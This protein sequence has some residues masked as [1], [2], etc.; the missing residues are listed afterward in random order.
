MQSL[1][2]HLYAIASSRPLAMGVVPRSFVLLL[3]LFL[4]GLAKCGT[5]IHRCVFL[6]LQEGTHKESRPPSFHRATVLTEEKA[7]SISDPLPYAIDVA[8]ASPPHKPLL[9]RHLDDPDL[10]ETVRL[11]VRELGPANLGNSPRITVP[12][13]LRNVL[14]PARA[15]AIGQVAMY[16]ENYALAWVVY[17]ALYARIRRRVWVEEA[18]SSTKGRGEPDH[19][20][21]CLCDAANGEV[22]GIAELSL[23]P[24]YWMTSPLLIPLSAKRFLSRLGNNPPP[25]QPNLGVDCLVPYVSN[26]VV[27]EPLRG[28]GYGKTLME[29]VERHA[30]SLQW[31]YLS[32]HVEGSD[33]GNGDSVEGEQAMAALALYQRMGYR[34]ITILPRHQVLPFTRREKGNEREEKNPQHVVEAKMLYLGKLLTSVDAV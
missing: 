9:V 24:P 8:S 4:P 14:G 32:L 3:A 34:R 31:N 23:Q 15:E 17:L 21:L 1:D 20:V 11:F 19:H 16:A 5:E 10:P 30:L 12:P 7:G 33:L 22:I 27:A 2:E 25:M 6:M 18:E 26:V 28:L 13:V 29:A